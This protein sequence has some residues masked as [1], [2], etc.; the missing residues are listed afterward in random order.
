MNDGMAALRCTMTVPVGLRMSN[1]M[2][3]KSVT[4]DHNHR[5]T[6]LGCSHLY[7]WNT[8]LEILCQKHHNIT[9]LG[10]LKYLKVLQRSTRWIWMYLKKKKFISICY[11]SPFF[12]WHIIDLGYSSRYKYSTITFKTMYKHY[13]NLTF[14]FLSFWIYWFIPI[15]TFWKWNIKIYLF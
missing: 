10:Q 5:A 7:I 4:A 13:L 6:L 9:S 8:M 1:S 2:N 15:L 14:L 12:L 3:T 11:C